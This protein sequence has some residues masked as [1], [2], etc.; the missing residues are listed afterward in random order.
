MIQIKHGINCV[1]NIDG[2]TSVLLTEKDGP[3]SFDKELEARLVRKG[4]AVYVHKPVA[5][6]PADE[7]D[8][9]QGNPPPAEKPEYNAEMK[10]TELKQ[11]LKAAG[12]RYKVGMTNADIVAA[13]D[14]H[15]GVAKELDEPD[16]DEDTDVD[17]TE[18]DV[19][20]DNEAP[21]NLSA[22]DPVL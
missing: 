9:D 2:K 10:A 21:P 19:V 8:R 7:T 1:V 3:Q 17:D 14:E 6:P 11:L 5:T 18:D 22:E 20:D 15:Y 16:P 12:L 13:L 4:L